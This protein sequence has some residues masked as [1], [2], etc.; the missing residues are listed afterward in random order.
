MK[1]HTVRVVNRFG[2]ST[3]TVKQ[4][5]DYVDLAGWKVI[6]YKEANRYGI[7]EEILGWPI[8]DKAIGPMYDGEGV[9]RYE[10]PDVAE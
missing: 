1:A 9:V 7:K 2:T 4:F 8:F 6:G 3:N 10:M 5:E